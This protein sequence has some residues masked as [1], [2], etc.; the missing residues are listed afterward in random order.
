MSRV[1]RDHR[2]RQVRE[3][4]LAGAQVCHICGGE[5]DFTAPPRS[6]KAPSVDHELPVSRTRGLDPETRQRLATDPR[7]MRPAHV[8]CN[9]KRGAGRKRP[10]HI[11]RGW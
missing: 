5:L 10:A 2:Y 6:P 8:G 11:S 4:V 9:S 7:L 1:G 3:R